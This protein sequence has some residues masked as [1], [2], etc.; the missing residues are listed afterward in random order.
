MTTK[1]C[2]ICGYSLEDYITECPN[3]RGRNFDTGN[4]FNMFNKKRK[5]KY[6]PTDAW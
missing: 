2:N 6:E 1:I 3:C 5:G 4:K